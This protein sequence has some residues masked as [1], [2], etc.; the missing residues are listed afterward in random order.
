MG[1]TEAEREARGRVGSGSRIYVCMVYC[2]GK[3]REAY[4]VDA[5]VGSAQVPALANDPQLGVQDH[6]VARKRVQLRQRFVLISRGG[7]IASDTEVPN[8][9]NKGGG[10]RERDGNGGEDP[11]CWRTRHRSMLQPRVCARRVKDG[12]QQ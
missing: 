2:K 4:L 11:N 3:C 10:G 8:V 7:E 1:S 5:L 6:L 12:L 9:C